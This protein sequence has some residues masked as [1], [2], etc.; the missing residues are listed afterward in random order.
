MKQQGY[1]ERTMGVQNGFHLGVESGKALGG[2]AFERR[3]VGRAGLSQV[4][5]RGSQLWNLGHSPGNGEERV[6]CSQS[7]QGGCWLRLRPWDL[8]VGE[9]QFHENRST[10]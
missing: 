8:P 2:V 5:S 6:S 4:E 3:D 10:P 1:I 9:V 7:S